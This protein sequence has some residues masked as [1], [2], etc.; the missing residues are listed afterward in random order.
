[1]IAA[2]CLSLI[3]SSA[4]GQDCVFKTTDDDS[5]TQA[6]KDFHDV[7]STLVHGTAEQGDFTAV[8]AKSG[9]LAGLRDKIMAAGIPSK[10]AKRCPE[11]ST[12]AKDLSGAVNTLVSQA[13]ANAP[14]DAVKTAFNAVHT[15]YRNLNGAMTSIEDMLDAFHE[16][17]QPL[18]HEAYPK[19]D[20]AAIKAE[21]PKLKVRAKIILGTAEAS[22]KA[23]APA[24]KALLDA[25]TT[26]EE[27]AAAKDDVAVLEALRIVHDLYEKLAGGHD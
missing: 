5:L 12:R 26:L 9:E 24:A 25:V 6:L 7:L 4:R 22:A 17:L 27:A 20:A 19:K 3:C 1:M 15:A 14:D 13:K 18:W 11:I 8:R 21:I 10:L 16:T 2:L 23:K